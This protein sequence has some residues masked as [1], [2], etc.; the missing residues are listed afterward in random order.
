MKRALLFILVCMCLTSCTRYV[1]EDLREE[2]VEE[3]YQ[4]GYE[5]GYAAGQSDLLKETDTRDNLKGSL[6][7]LPSTPKVQTSE[8][9]DYVL[10]TS[11]KK[12]HKTTCDS[13][14]AMK[15]KNREDVRDTKENIMEAGYSP[16]GNCNP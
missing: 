10:N 13:V 7:D 5:D 1:D 15:A 8:A 16:C 2:T 12:F 9:Q 4:R 11:S 3:A 6:Y 14:K